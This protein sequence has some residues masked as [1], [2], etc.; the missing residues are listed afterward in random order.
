MTRSGGPISK[1]VSSR[2]YLKFHG[3]DLFKIE[4]L[5]SA[6]A[7]ELLSIKRELDAMTASCDR[8]NEDLLKD[9]RGTPSNGVH[10]MMIISQR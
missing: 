8:Y 3:W 1:M 4:V 10:S 9:P 6:A 7:Y 2:T 5:A